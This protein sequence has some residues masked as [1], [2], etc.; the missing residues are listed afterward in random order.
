MSF[1][2]YRSFR[3]VRDLFYTSECAIIFIFYIKLFP[4]PPSWIKSRDKEERGH[5]EMG[6]EDEKK[7]T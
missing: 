4:R 3:F 6:W 2:C 1:C 5:D 7:E